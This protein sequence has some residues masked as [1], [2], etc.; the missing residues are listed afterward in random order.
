MTDSVLVL[1]LFGAVPRPVA[2]TDQPLLFALIVALLGVTAIFLFLHFRLR[3]TLK[4][5]NEDLR[6]ARSL[7][8]SASQFANIAFFD[9]DM[10]GCSLGGKFV[11]N[12]FWGF[13]PDGKPIALEQWVYEPDQPAIRQA[14]RQFLNSSDA[15]ISHCYRAMYNGKLCHFELCAGKRFDSATGKPHIVGFIREVSQREGYREQM[16]DALSLQ[17]TILD[18]LP[19][20]LYAKNVE[21]D[22]RYISC[23][24]HQDRDGQN[25]YLGKTDYE[26]FPPSVAEEYREE[27]RQLVNG[28]PPVDRLFRQKQSDGTTKILRLYKKMLHKANGQ[29]LILTIM[30]DITKEQ[31]QAEELQ[32]TTALLQHILDHLP[33][34]IFVKNADNDFRY[35]LCNTNMERAFGKKAPE[36]LGKN[37][38]ELWENRQQAEKFHR[39]DLAVAEYGR[40]LTFTE[41][42]E[43]RHGSSQHCRLTKC[44]GEKA[45][46]DRL[47]LGLGVDISELEEKRADLEQANTILHAV[48][49]HLPAW[50]AVKESDNDFRYLIWNR[51]AA[52][53]T[54]VSPEEVLGKTDLEIPPLA[55]DAARFR[56]GDR[57]AVRQ[58]K[59]RMEHQ[60]VS[61]AGAVHH[62]D[63]TIMALPECG[64]RNLEL[65]MSLDVTERRRLQQASYEKLLL[66][67]AVKI[68]MMLFDPGH[69]LIRVN[70]AAREIAGIPEEQIYAQPCYKSFCSFP[71]PPDNCPV[72]LG[73]LDHKMHHW[74]ITLGERDYL[75]TAYP[76]MAGEE[77][78]YVLKTLIDITEANRNRQQLAEA[79]EQANCANR[80]KSYF[81]ATVSHEIRTPLNAVLGFTE[82]LQSSDL[83]EAERAE[84]LDS[85]NVAGHSLLNLLNDV[86]N[87][88]KIEAE[89]QDIEPRPVSLNLLLQEVA[90]VFRHE[91]LRKNLYLTIEENNLPLL[92]LDIQ[93]L[94][95][96]LVNLIGNAVKFTREGGITIRPAYSNST[97]LTIEISDT[98]IGIAED[99]L[100]AIFLP[101]NQQDTMRDA[102]LY[103]GSGLGLAIVGKLT[104]KLNGEITVTSK[105][106][107]GSTF[108]VHFPDITP[109]EAR[110]RN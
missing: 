73:L 81:L 105:T 87:L 74:E 72:R 85:I 100:E 49:N 54:G 5:A 25:P 53:L 110:D 76:I 103:R 34:F 16:E 75:L 88:S 19:I 28:G 51:G 96:I 60:W 26:L 18:N 80:A 40:E 77:L 31:Q 93:R 108:T 45:N 30:A 43:G 99:Q 65:V 48:L 68:P 17:K 11:D 38:F 20:Y 50:I 3:R 15:T 1:M 41:T 91:T 4:N 9:S 21:D 63:T 8:D 92:M 102:H 84:Y 109:V 47:V 35:E 64:G 71:G 10:D 32:N 36:I 86:L 46:G 39:T 79:L 24:R 69:H 12:R 29:R 22:F 78:R 58:G 13:N 6:Q 106:G 90:T 66:I 2:G 61:P 83:S 82:I 37:D 62:F 95:Q 101:F 55:N 56:D 44:R 57:E 67:D 23:S 27:D 33:G 104:Q 7:L 98:G 52:E 70:N 14:L 94:R 107:V 97:G 59:T 89:H 42:I